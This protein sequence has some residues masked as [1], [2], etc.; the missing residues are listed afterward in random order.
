MGANQIKKKYNE[1]YEVI[2]NILLD[3]V[4][5][6]PSEMISG[7]LELQPKYNLN[8]TIFNDTKVIFKITQFQE[9]SYTTDSG[10]DETTEYVC[11]YSNVL[12]QETSFNYFSGAN[13]LLVIKIPFS[14]LIPLEIQPTF[15]YKR[16]FIKHF[17]C[18]ELPGI[19][20]YLLEIIILLN[21]FLIIIIILFLIFKNY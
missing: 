2:V 13:I 19:N 7:F 16:H 15:Y 1:E 17:F 6:F 18:V 20:L 21:S 4:C 11:E 12:T 9:Y 5:Y 10:D 8:Q 3:K 14:I